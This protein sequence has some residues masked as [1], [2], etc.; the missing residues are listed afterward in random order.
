MGARAGPPPQL[1]PPCIP[2]LLLPPLLPLPD[3]LSPACCHLLL[4]QELLDSLGEQA[5]DITGRPLLKDVGSS[6]VSGMLPGPA[7]CSAAVSPVLLPAALRLLACLL[8]RL[9]A[10]PLPAPY[11]QIK[12]AGKFKAHFQYPPC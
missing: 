4:L 1:L 6:N 9:L 2:L 8:T 5:M 11:P 3:M 12:P 7:S 10:F